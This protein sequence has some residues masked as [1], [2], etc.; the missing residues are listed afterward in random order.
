MAEMERILEDEKG[1]KASL[2]VEGTNGTENGGHG[3]SAESM[4]VWRELERTLSAEEN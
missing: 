4:E 3:V 1:K 2:T